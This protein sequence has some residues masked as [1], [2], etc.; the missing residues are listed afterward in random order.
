MLRESLGNTQVADRL[1]LPSRSQGEEVM[2][3]TDIGWTQNPSDT[4][5]TFT[6]DYGQLN[7]VQPGPEHQFRED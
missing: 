7:I 4:V 1:G 2:H 5:H 3:L 6:I